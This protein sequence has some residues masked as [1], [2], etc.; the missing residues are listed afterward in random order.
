MPLNEVVGLSSPLASA[1]GAAAAEMPTRDAVTAAAATA[2]FIM[3]DSPSVV[4]ESI[5][6]NYTRPCL[7]ARI[8]S[9]GELR[10]VRIIRLSAQRV[11]LRNH[12]DPGELFLSQ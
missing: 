10:A 7:V 2:F 11:N 5:R 6:T 9:D 3:W 4:S 12:R 1:W 8:H